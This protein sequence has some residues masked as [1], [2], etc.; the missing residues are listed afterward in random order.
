M[1]VV[2]DLDTVTELSNVPRPEPARRALSFL[3]RSTGSCCPIG[4]WTTLPTI[5]QK[6]RWALFGSINHI[7]ICSVPR[8][9]FGPPND[10]AI[11]GHPLSDRGLYPFGVFQVDR[12]RWCATWN[13]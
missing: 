5:R 9:L 11:A 4:L 1:Y 12:Y 6:H 2:N 13:G 8:N 7:C 10:E 3:R